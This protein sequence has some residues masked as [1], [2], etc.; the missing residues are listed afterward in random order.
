VR[1]ERGGRRGSGL[2]SAR[3]LLFRGYRR[4]EIPRAFDGHDDYAETVAAAVAA[5]DLPDYTVAEGNGAYRQ[6]TAHAHGG[7]P[8]LLAWLVRE[9]GRPYA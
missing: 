2:A 7:M 1:R 8:A 9:S 5:A 3:P 6:R 4:A